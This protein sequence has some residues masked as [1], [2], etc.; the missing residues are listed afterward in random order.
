MSLLTGALLLVSLSFNVYVHTRFE[1]YPSLVFAVVIPIIL[2][3]AYI[4]QPETFL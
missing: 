1:N 4:G 2:Y 3:A